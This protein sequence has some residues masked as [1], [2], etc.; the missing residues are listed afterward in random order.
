MESPFKYLAA[1]A[2]AGAGLLVL[3]HA[4]RIFGGTVVT[5]EVSLT[6]HLFQ[7]ISMNLRTLSMTFHPRRKKLQRSTRSMAPGWKRGPSH[8]LELGGVYG[9]YSEE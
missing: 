4:V 2:A 1:A 9:R 7:T 5:Q 8:A 3:S 6:G